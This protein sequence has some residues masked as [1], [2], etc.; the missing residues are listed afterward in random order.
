[1]SQTAGPVVVTPEVRDACTCATV[2]RDMR[3]WTA[4]TLVVLLVTLLTAVA[5]QLITNRL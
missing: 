5:V 2:G 4:A 1:M 3:G